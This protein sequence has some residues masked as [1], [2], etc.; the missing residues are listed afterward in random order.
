MSTDVNRASGLE[1]HDLNCGFK[2]YRANVVQALAIPGEM[3]RLIPAI[4]AS[5]Q[6]RGC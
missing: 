2:V 6:A 1:L 5:A 4:A 3:Y